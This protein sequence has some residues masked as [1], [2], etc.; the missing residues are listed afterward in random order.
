MAGREGF[1]PSVEFYPDNRLAG[2]PDRP[3]R[4]LPTI[5]AEGEGFEP[6]VR[7]DPTVVFKTTA[8][9]HSAIPPRFRIIASTTVYHAPTGSLVCG[10]RSALAVAHSQKLNTAPNTVPEIILRICNLLVESLRSRR[11]AAL[12]SGGAP[13]ASQA[14]RTLTST[15]RMHFRYLVC[16]DCSSFYKPRSIFGMA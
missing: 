4:H 11:C 14:S 6:P 7:F 3:L 1:E 9:V 10:A 8:I 13:R 15:C 2:G 12:P 16:G 5:L